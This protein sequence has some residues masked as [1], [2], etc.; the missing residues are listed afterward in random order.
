[1]SPNDYRTACRSTTGLRF[2]GTPSPN[3]RLNH[4][5]NVYPPSGSP[6]TGEHPPSPSGYSVNGVW[7]TYGREQNVL[8]S[9]AIG[10][11][12]EEE[13]PWCSSPQFGPPKRERERRPTSLVL[14]PASSGGPALQVLSPPPV[15]VSLAARRGTTVPSPLPRVPSPPEQSRRTTRP[16]QHLYESTHDV[17]EPRSSASL[18]PEEG[19]IQIR[20]RRADSNTSLGYR[21]SFKHVRGLTSRTLPT[22][23]RLLQLSITAAPVNAGLDRLDDDGIQSGSE[24]SPIE[25]VSVFSSDE[26]D[27]L[28]TPPDDTIP[29]ITVTKSGN[30]YS[31]TYK[32]NYSSI[33]VGE[34]KYASSFLDFEPGTP[35]SPPSPA[36]QSPFSVAQ[37]QMFIYNNLHA[38]DGVDGLP[39]QSYAGTSTNH[40]KKQRDR[41]TRRRASPIPD[42]IIDN[43]HGSKTRPGT[44][45]PSMPG[46]G[47]RQSA[48]SN[49][50]KTR[51]SGT[52]GAR[53]TRVVGKSHR[54]RRSGVVRRSHRPSS[55]SGHNMTRRS[56][57][58]GPNGSNSVIGGANLRPEIGSKMKDKSPSGVAP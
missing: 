20:T 57:H 28:S 19:L 26:S 15:R 2:K 3:G 6:V 1:M 13:K 56:G 52:S 7:S 4:E 35:L 50:G 42:P 58:Q 10:Y 48:Y 23:S 11:L 12:N 38:R 32:H 55:R 33:R 25:S 16:S 49:G 39:E 22:A 17:S 14:R 37:S 44:L 34:D 9:Q 40:H 5:N 24:E 31:A 54:R 18:T 41:G 51:A 30:D 53:G 27:L 21:R 47:A 29:D 43:P 8:I 36:A 45:N 46:A